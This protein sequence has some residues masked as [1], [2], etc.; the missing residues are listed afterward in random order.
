MSAKV[1]LQKTASDPAATAGTGPGPQGASRLSAV[2]LSQG[3]ARR[4]LLDGLRRA[5]RRLG[6]RPAGPGTTGANGGRPTAAARRNTLRIELHTYRA[7]LHRLGKAL[8]Y[9]PESRTAIRQPG[10]GRPVAGLRRSGTS[11][12]SS[13]EKGKRAIANR[14][15]SK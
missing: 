7:R 3:V 14:K 2:L 11:A 4:D 9:V 12:G 8:G 10:C 1:K 5:M 15:G 13:S 6:R